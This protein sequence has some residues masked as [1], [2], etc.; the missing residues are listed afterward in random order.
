MLCEHMSKSPGLKFD[1]DSGCLIVTITGRY[2]LEHKEEA[3]KSIAAAIKAK[4]VKAA[5][6]D[7]R[8]LQN[9][10][11]FM[12]R[13]KMGEYAGHYLT[14]VPIGCLGHEQQFDPG[15]IGKV[16][17]NNRGAR[18]ELFTDEAAGYAWLKQYQTGS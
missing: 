8:G 13:Y 2:I 10:Y 7:M 3:F 17:A 14:A 12:D 1:Y 5:L 9:P 18:V 16:V 15:R 11:G 6:I 4:P